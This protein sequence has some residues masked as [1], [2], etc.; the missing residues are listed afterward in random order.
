MTNHWVDLQNCK[1]IL[2]EGSNVA[3]NH[4]MAFK[5]IRKAQENGAKIIHV[6]PRF[7]RTSAAA[8]VYARIRPGTDAAFQNTMINHI[9][10]NKLYDEDY[11]TTHTNALYLGNDREDLEPEAPTAD[12]EPAALDLGG[13]PTDPHTPRARGCDH[14]ERAAR[15][16][17]CRRRF[18]QPPAG[19]VHVARDQGAPDDVLET[20]D[21][22]RPLQRFAT[23]GELWAALEGPIEH[24]PDA[25]EG[26]PGEPGDH[27]MHPADDPSVTE[28]SSP[29]PRSWPV[30]EVKDAGTAP[31]EQLMQLITLPPRIALG[32]V[33]GI[34][35]AVRNGVSAVESRTDSRSDPKRRTLMDPDDSAVK[36]DDENGDD[37]DTPSVRQLLHAATGD[38]DA[39][40]KALADRAGGV[41]EDVA[42]LPSCSRTATYRADRLRNTMGHHETPRR[43]ATA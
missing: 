24:R 35:G 16:G 37:E 17:C 39:E 11:V 40:A 8:D 41:S 4:P 7:T 38:R 26:Q 21:A 42:R 36:P 30:V 12:E 2:V 19:L 13:S 27:A 20:L 43:Y 10:V 5:W 34:T 18:Q 28:L 22:L 23:V 32:V 15:A 25:V 29:P 31:A 9:L 6:D 3:E 1:T 33:R 14:T